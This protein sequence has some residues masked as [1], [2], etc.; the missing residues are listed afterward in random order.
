MKINS[1]VVL[2]ILPALVLGLMNTVLI[3]PGDIGSWKNY[4]GYGFLLIAAVN[5]T[6]QL[7]KYY[8]K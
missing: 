6:I 1:A 5:L 3:R 8:K 2:R 4:V 7:I